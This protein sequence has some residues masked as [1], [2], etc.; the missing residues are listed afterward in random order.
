M[1]SKIEQQVMASVGVIYTAR[2]LMS[3]TAIEL[4]MLAVSAIALWQL[5][6]VH[7]VLD[8]FFAVEKHGLGSTLT[9]LATAVGHTNL[10]VQFALI[11]AVVA[12]ASLV[13]D[14][15]RST[16]PRQSFAM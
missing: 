12:F 14:F 16:S 3:R 15:V 1:Q 8:N 4:Y 13:T 7:K 2:K 11:V 5:V 9:Y 6:W 10:A